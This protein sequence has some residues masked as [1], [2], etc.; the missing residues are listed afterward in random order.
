MKVSKSKAL[1]K[2]IVEVTKTD[3]KVTKK[4]SKL[5]LNKLDSSF[6]EIQMT[7]MTKI[8]AEQR[9]AARIIPT[10]AKLLVPT[11]ETLE[12]T[13]EDLANLLKDF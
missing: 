3:K 4:S 10:K 7:K 5:D 1:D 6:S 11:G 13:S 9:K 12:K 8:A 2:R